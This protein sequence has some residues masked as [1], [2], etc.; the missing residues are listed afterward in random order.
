V[1]PLTIRASVTAWFIGLT[2]ALIGAF[3]VTLVTSL[4]HALRDG[5][6][7]ALEARAEAMAGVCAW[8]DE[9]SDVEFKLSADLAAVAGAERDGRALEV[10]T[11]PGRR[12]LHRSGVPIPL[13]A[14]E[15]AHDDGST[16][17]VEFAD[18][19]GAPPRRLCTLRAHVPALPAEDD[20]PDRPAFDVLVRTA[21]GTA[22]VEAQLARM[23]WL[24]LVLI[25]ASSLVVLAFAAFLSRRFVARLRELGGAA[26]AVRAGGRTAM[27]RRGNG[28]EVDRLAEIL[29]VAFASLE[30][31]RDRQARFTANAAHELRNP[32][33]IL[34]NAAEVALRHERS[35]DEYRRFLGDVLATSERTARILEALL[36]LARLDAERFH[37]RFSDVDLLAVV[38]QSAANLAGPTGRIEVTNGVEAT[39]RGQEALL[40]V[41]VD[42]LLA[43]ALRF[44]GGD[45]ARGDSAPVAVALENDADGRVV[46]H[47]RDHGPGIPDA[48]KERVFE[49]FFRGDADGRGHDG[50]G[51]GLSIVADVARLHDAECRIEDAAPGTRITVHFPRGG[52]LGNWSGRRGRG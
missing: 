19:A 2:M 7:A 8:D 23:R 45:A 11:W 36:L 51:L 16:E 20:D 30:D 17:A 6:D 34:R 47:V 48:L 40:R 52:A 13:P 10:W 39:V 18:L 28:D 21:D 46:L 33:T 3:A 43:N 26:A 37:A 9:I 38:R 35:P 25:G 22:A 5:V 50:A 4:G 49:R 31:A 29:D 41:L 12:L 24:L 42:N 1:K 32:I 14:A 44:A 15:P 27:P